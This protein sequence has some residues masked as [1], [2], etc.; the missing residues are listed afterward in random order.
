MVVPPVPASPAVQ[1]LAQVAAFLGAGL[2]ISLLP[3]NRKPRRDEEYYLDHPEEQ[4]AIDA[5]LTAAEVKRL[6]RQQRNLKNQQEK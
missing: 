4:A 2:G 3:R 5:R 6:R 1:Q